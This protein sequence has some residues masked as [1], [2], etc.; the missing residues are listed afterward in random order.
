MDIMAYSKILKLLELNDVIY[1]T[2]IASKLFTIASPNA[3]STTADTT[4]TVAETSAQSLLSIT[5]SFY[6]LG[7]YVNLQPQ[8]ISDLWHW[9]KTGNSEDGY[10]WTHTMTYSVAN[11]Y[12][13]IITNDSSVGV[14][15]SFAAASNAVKTYSG[16][17]GARP[18]T[19]SADYLGSE[20]LDYKHIIN[21][22][23][24]TVSATDKF[25]KKM[26]DSTTIITSSSASLFTATS[27]CSNVLYVPKRT[28]T[29]LTSLNVTAKGT[30][31]IQLI[32]ALA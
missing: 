32:Y 19:S 14:N 24:Y 7:I 8:I 20:I 25:T 2:N 9:V 28:L 3:T 27:A 18:V 29:P 17:S 22:M 21:N 26:T 5:G 1:D 11:S 12:A 13:N 16:G 23:I 6:L 4:V 15:F 30:A 31:T 10:T